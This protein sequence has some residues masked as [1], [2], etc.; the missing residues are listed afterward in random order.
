MR[1]CHRTRSLLFLISLT[2]PGTTTAAPEDR[3]EVLRDVQQFIRQGNLAQAETRLT[4]ALKAFPRDAALYDLSGVVHAQQGNYSKAESDFRRAL[5][6]DPLLT[7]AYINLGH[8]YQ[9][10]SARDPD[11]EHKALGV[12]RSLL[13][14]DPRNLE[15][16]YQSALLSERQ[17]NYR[18]SLDYLSRLPA[19]GQQRAQA[20]SVRCGDLAGLREESKTRIAAESLLNAPGLTQSDILPLLPLLDANRWD[21]IEEKLLEG[22]VRRGVTGSDVPE[23]LA[24]F[25]LRRGRLNDARSKLE[26]VAQ[27][28]PEVSTLLELARIADQQKDYKGALGYLAHARDLNPG[29]ARVHFFFGVVSAEENLVEEAYRSLKESVR[30]APDNPEYNCALGMIAQKRATPGEAVPYFKKYC[31]LRPGDPRGRLELGI[32]YFESHQ[33]SMARKELEDL[34]RYPETAAPAHFFLGRIANENGNYPEALQQVQQALASD[35]HYADAY[36]EEGIIYMKQKRYAP[37]ER[38]LL[39]AL[40]ISPEHYA[41]NLN[42]MML[43]QR[44]DSKQAE[45]Q[46]RR[47]EEVKKKRAENSRLAVR[48]IE[49]V[50]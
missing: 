3:A 30:L 9:Q 23:A 25:Y 21:E 16:N 40:S 8:L 20:L 43:Y 49:I 2:L 6:L 13:R 1:P 24:R 41:A 42:L 46:A 10:N 5:A 7:G 27:A 29:D 31:E 32:S 36:A 50:R 47:F 44:T 15:A 19:D 37:A 33:D 28:R 48:S 35:T 22:A 39:R 4:L 17:K 26:G 12:Y 38:A 45:A 34:V 11:A 14:L 18:A